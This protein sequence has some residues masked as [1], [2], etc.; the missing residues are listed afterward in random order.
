MGLAYR[1]LKQGGGGP[2]QVPAECS[3]LELA[4]EKRKDAMMK[5]VQER[6]KQGDAATESRAEKEARESRIIR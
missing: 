6:A 3:T 2:E 4:I 1:T 5:R